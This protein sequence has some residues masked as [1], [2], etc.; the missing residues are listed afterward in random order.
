[1]YCPLIFSF[2][3]L[4]HA[5]STNVSSKRLPSITNSEEL[6]NRFPEFDSATLFVNTLLST[7]TTES[8]TD[9]VFVYATFASNV[10]LEIMDW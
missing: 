3:E 8:F 10:E 7:F 5:S 1:M 6:T 9:I 2:N 4:A